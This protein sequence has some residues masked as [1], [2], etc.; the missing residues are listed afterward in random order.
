MKFR[1]ESE[2]RRGPG[3]DFQ[4]WVGQQSLFERKQQ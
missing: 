3:G 1:M 4:K 2:D